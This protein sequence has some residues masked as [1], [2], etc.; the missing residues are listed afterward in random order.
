MALGLLTSP[1][2]AQSV[3]VNAGIQMKPDHFSVGVHVETPPI[4]DRLTFRPNLQISPANSWTPSGG[5]TVS[6][7]STDP[8]QGRNPTVLGFNFEF[9]YQVATRTPWSFYIGGG[10]GLV[11][12]RATSG[13][14][15]GAGANLLV[16]AQHAR[17][18]FVEVRKGFVESPS[19]TFAAGYSTR[20]K[21]KW[22]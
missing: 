6:A 18:L 8:T 14:I 9:A 5:P 12:T 4:V 22:P 15:S 17:G 20:L 11:L 21:L 7:A 1:A 10:P 19:M 13:T 2:G 3:G 16:G